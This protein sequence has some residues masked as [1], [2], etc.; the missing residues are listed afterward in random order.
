MKFYNR[1]GK[2]FLAL[3]LVAML[4]VIIPLQGCSSSTFISV[5][6]EIAPAVTDVLQ[7]VALL[8]DKSVD[9][10]L[11]AKISADVA[12]LE[13]LYSAFETADASAKGNI[14]AE[15][16]AAFT[17]LNSDLSAIFTL[18]QVSDPMTQAKITALIGLIQVAVSIAEAV[19]SSVDLAK[20]SSPSIV[21]ASELAVAYDRIL[22]APTGNAKVD[23]YTKTHLI[24]NHGSLV[25]HLSLGIAK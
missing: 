24:H 6:N 1:F 19:I 17:T 10:S 13:S 3:F 5:L 14:K 12:A 23:A 22:V 18:A 15:I 11:P 20:T 8:K 16:Q 4:G 2:S 7:I 21:T 9:T 25:R